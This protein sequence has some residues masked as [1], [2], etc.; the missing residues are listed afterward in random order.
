MGPK[1]D[2]D[3]LARHSP[4]RAFPDERR[5]RPFA[6]RGANRHAILERTSAAAMSS[7]I[8]K[9]ERS[10]MKKKAMLEESW[11]AKYL[12]NDSSLVYFNNARL[13]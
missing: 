3:R 2:I 5:R 6:P 12:P 13:L 8:D 10:F 11:W 7:K 4:A 1:K 9:L